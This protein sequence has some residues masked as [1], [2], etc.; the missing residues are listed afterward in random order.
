MNKMNSPKILTIGI[1]GLPYTLLQSLSDQGVTPNL[2]NLLNSGDSKP[3]VSS[4]PDISST[5]WTGFMTGVNPGEH[6]IYGFYEPAW[7]YNLRFP[8]ARDI[9][10]PTI[11]RQLGRL[12]KKS[13]IVNMPQTYPAL[14]LNGTLI[15]GFVAPD[16]EKSVYPPKYLEALKNL[17]YQVDVNAWLARTDQDQFFE[18]LFQVLERRMAGIDFLWNTEKWDFATIVFTGTDRLQHYFWDAV[19]DESHQNHQTA[20]GFYHEIDNAVG[21]LLEKV[22]DSTMVIVLSDHGFTKIIREVNL[23]VWLRRNDYLKFRRPASDSLE[24]I[25]ADSIAFCVDPGRVYI[26][27]TDRFSRGKIHPGE[28]FLKV[29][30]DLKAKLENEVLIRDSLG[31]RVNP[32]EKVVL[33]EEI[34]SG[35]LLGKAPDLIVL[36]K[37]GFDLKGNVKIDELAR[38]DVLTG[39][40]TR[41]NASL[42]VHNKSPHFDFDVLKSIE[43]IAPQILR[44]YS[45]D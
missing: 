30:A 24:D 4:I 23:N 17:N 8:T 6:G 18:Q 25:D 43:D 20:L 11:W 16:L 31:T 27:R 5:A 1:D 33:P 34:Y 9:Q 2:K 44:C 42:I 15:S 7:D 37:P 41:E 45:E 22:D 21:K 36:A 3:I 32:V 26:N 38:N 12:H 39:M 28:E 13:L 29:R 35:P 19:D 14:P 40:H 10:S